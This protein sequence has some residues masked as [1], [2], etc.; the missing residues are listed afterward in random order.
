MNLPVFANVVVFAL[1]IAFLVRRRRN[2]GSVSSNVLLAVLLGVAL[3]A[4]AQTVYGL[5]S[6]AIAGTLPWV[7]IVGTGYVRLLQMVISPLVLVSILAAV[8]K[9]SNARSLGAI[10]GSV[11]GL[12]MLTTALSALIGIGMTQLLGLRAD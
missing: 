1:T 8:T 12:L 11:L 9:L 2:G 6:P 7:G 5:G 3:G 10:S 4:L